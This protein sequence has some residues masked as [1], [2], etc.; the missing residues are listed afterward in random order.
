ML[1]R[2]KIGFA[3]SCLL[4]LL[5][6][7]SATMKFL[8]PEEVISGFA[9]FKLSEWRVIIAIG[10]TVGAILLVIPKTKNFGALVMSSYLGGAIMAHMTVGESFAG[11]AVLVVLV[12]I[13]A[14][15][16]HPQFLCLK[17]DSSASAAHQQ[18]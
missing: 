16:R 3:L 6:L 9:K 4:S 7:M 17:A 10:E 15:L 18:S 5:F 13:I 1:T 2:A 12:W 14:W 11:P 8:A